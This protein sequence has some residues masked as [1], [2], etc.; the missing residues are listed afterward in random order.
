[1]LKR[2]AAP[3]AALFAG[4]IF[5]DQAIAGSLTLSYG[6]A[7]KVYTAHNIL[8]SG[9]QRVAKSGDRETPTPVQYHFQTPEL[10]SDAGRNAYWLGEALRPHEKALEAAMARA[11]PP[12]DGCKI[13]KG[14]DKETRE[15][16]TAGL[17]QQR[18]EQEK[19][20]ATMVTI[21]PFVT[22]SE[23]DVRAIKPAA[24]VI[25]YG[26]MMPAWRKKD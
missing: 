14:D 17:A 6:D 1:M 4:L 2:L 10:D 7:Q 16:K 18:I 13:E 22:F 8:M 21:D 20:D 5:G 15:R 11:C 12:P 24:P 19:T 9:E 3:A 25:V 23:A 26:L